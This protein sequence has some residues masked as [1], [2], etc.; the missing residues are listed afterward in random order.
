MRTRIFVVLLVAVSAAL[1]AL[2][3]NGVSQEKQANPENKIAELMK[4]R[5]D[6]LQKRV[7]ALVSQYEAGE[8]QIMSVISARDDLYQAELELASAKADRVKICELR[9][10][11]MAEL[12][13]V[14]TIRYSQGVGS[15]EDKLL[16][17]A[18]KL[19]AEIDLL[20]E[21]RSDGK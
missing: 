21:K 19:Q 2:S 11:N 17:T 12:E 15:F 16:A 18:A 3:S 8:I 6:I 9:F 7:D 4:Q 20:R 5:R 13:K 14:T 10:K 1:F